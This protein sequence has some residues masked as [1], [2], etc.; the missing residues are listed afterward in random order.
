M[1]NDFGL[2]LFALDDA[3]VAAASDADIDGRPTRTW[4]P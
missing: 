1:T 2:M 3:L 4:S